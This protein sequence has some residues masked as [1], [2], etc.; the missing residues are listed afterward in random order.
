MKEGI[1]IESVGDYSVVRIIQKILNAPMVR[2][3][4]DELVA[5]AEARRNLAV[6]V[7]HVRHID[8]VGLSLLLA[9]RSRAHRAGSSMVLLGVRDSLKETLRLA[10]LGEVF[11]M[12]DTEPRD[13]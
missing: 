10:G 3:V 9:L 6:D 7:T 1:R 8:S 5:L 12:I 2:D 11:Q 13:H 4:F